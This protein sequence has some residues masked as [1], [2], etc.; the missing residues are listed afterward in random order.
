HP[1]EIRAVLSAAREAA[2]NRVIAVVQPHRFTRLRDLMTDFQT[3]FNDADVVHVAPVYPAGE[4][5]IDGVD[6]TALVGGLRARGHRAATA[7]A[8]PDELAQVLADSIEPG[9]L[10][11]CLGAGDITRWAAGLAEAIGKERAA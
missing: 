11:V 5:P 8:G 7:V 9:D 6:A 10:V 4:D 1:V 3:A 2:G